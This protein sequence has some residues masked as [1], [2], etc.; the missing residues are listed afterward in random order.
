MRSGSPRTCSVVA[1]SP[2]SGPVV[3]VTSR[4]VLGIGVFNPF[5]RHP[6]L[7]AMEI[8]SL[9]EL[10]GGRATLALGSG[11]KGLLEQAGIGHDKP[12]EA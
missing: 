7:I 9:D 10:S 4:I 11:V 1:F 2:S 3:A 8:A 6:T 5:N 12:L